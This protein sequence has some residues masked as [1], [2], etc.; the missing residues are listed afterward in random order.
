[1]TTLL[2]IRHGQSQANLT[3]CFAGQI[4]APLT[5]LGFRQAERTAEFVAAH[6]QIDRVYASDLRRAVC[7]GQAVAQKLGLP[8]KTEKALREIDAGQW[9]GIPFDQLAQDFPEEYGLWLA[10]IGN[11]RPVGGESVA[12]LAQRIEKAL[13]AVA[14]ENPDKT[15]AVAIHAIPIRSVQ[16]RLSG[17]PLSYM[18]QIPWVTNASVTELFF[19]DGNFRLGKVAQ[20]AHLADLITTLPKTV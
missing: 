7:T 12:E 16:W 9:E 20:D 10:D 3:R 5:E 14:E 17:E 6:Y 13:T 8:L 18:T 1:M 11:S 19:E 15:V 2:L 4:D